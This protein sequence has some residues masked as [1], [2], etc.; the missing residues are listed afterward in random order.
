MEMS[1]PNTQVFAYHGPRKPEYYNQF[2]NP[3]L[4]H[5]CKSVDKGNLILCDQCC[6]IS[7][8]N[9]EH[10]IM[11]YPNHEKICASITQVLQVRPQTDTSRYNNWQQW[12]QSRKELLELIQQRFGRPMKP[13]MQQMILWSKSCA[14]CHR[15]AELNVCGRCFS[16]NYCNE[17][18]IDFRKKHDEV[19]CDQLK[20]LLNIDIETISGNTI[21][22]CYD[23]LLS[24]NEKADFEEMLE[25]CIEYLLTPRENI[26]WLAKDYVQSDYLSEPLTVYSGCQRTETLYILRGD[27]IIIHII[28]A[29]SMDM[30]SLPA[31]EIL[32]HLIPDIQ[33]LS[34]ILIGPELQN[35]NKEHILCDLCINKNKELYFL[36][37]SMLYH[38]FVASDLHM[39]PNI[40]VGFQVDFSERHTYS[41]IIKAIKDQCV[42]LILSFSHKQKAWDNIN[43]I[44][45]IV[46]FKLELDINRRN[47]FGGLAPHRD[48]ETGNGV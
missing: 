28:V 20:L 47:F 27:S 1:N 35:S 24:I 48:L 23:F 39:S 14:V 26:N 40:V 10:K 22:M 30:N 29:N 5:V 16:A 45:D 2:F 15:Q 6:L 44:R 33:N 13:Y 36:S 4:C 38:D 25:F 18:V 43:K 9:E 31:W 7:Y 41:K 32:L 8:C 21:D 34:I 3:N 17:H 12:I 42:L 11:H 37:F 46:D 19:K